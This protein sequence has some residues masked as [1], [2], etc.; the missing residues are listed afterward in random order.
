MKEKEFLDVVIPNKNE[1]EFI[2]MAKKLR[3][4][5]LIFLY[6][7]EKDFFQTTDLKIEIVNGIIC[8]GED[9]FKYKS[10]GIFVALD[11]L[12]LGKERIRKAF[13]KFKPNLIFNLE[14]LEA[15]DPLHFRAAGL[16]EP[17]AKLAAENAI[18]IAFNFS[19]FLNAPA[20]KRALLLGRLA[21]NARLCRKYRANY[22]I[23]TFAREP[24][25][26]RNPR[27]LACFL[28]ILK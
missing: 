20:E 3:Y 19:N 14:E 6:E 17:S 23:A 15:K 2:E 5:K 13:E 9:V 27:D 28:E 1:M 8:K 18:L 12:E 22:F 7:S 16:D 24:L 4:K 10:K 25:E 11:A 21:Q 26:M